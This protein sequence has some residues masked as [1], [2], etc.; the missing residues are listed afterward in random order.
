MRRIK[1]HA[2]RVNRTGGFR[3]RSFQLEN[4]EVLYDGLER[5]QLQLPHGCLAGACGACK[6]VIL[7]G[8]QNLDRPSVIEQDTLDA[9]YK[10]NPHAH[11]KVIRL[12]C[13]A[14]VLGPIKA[15][16]FK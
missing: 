13:R 4:E 14:K 2:H 9:I 5:Q 10:N 16:P 3:S 12:S 11:G 8:D 15:T 6:V 7:E 1:G